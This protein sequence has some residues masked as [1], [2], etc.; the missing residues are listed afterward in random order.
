MKY[1]CV[2]QIDSTDCG[3]ACL[4]TI[5]NHYN[6]FMPIAK[7]RELAGTDK[8]G[9]NVYGMVQAARKLGFDADGV[10]GDEES[11]F[12][13]F[14][15]PAIAHVVIDN[16]LLHYVVIHS[17]SKD[18][19]VVADP[20]KGIVNYTPQDFLK[21]WSGVMILL[22]PDNNFTQSKKK[23][24]L[25]RFF[26]MVISQKK[27]LTPIFISSLII[28]ATGIL[29]SFYYSVIMDSILL[30][31]SY[32][33][34]LTISLCV[35]GLYIVKNIL[36]Y[37]RGRLILNLSKKI[38]LQLIPEFNK[39]LLRLPLSFFQMRKCGEIVSRYSDASKIRDALSDAV[40]TIMIDSLMALGGGI[41]L[42]LQNKLL[43]FIALGM[44]VLYGS[45]VLLY[46]KPI[47]KANRSVME[48]NAQFSAYLYESVEGIETIKAMNNEAISERKSKNLYDKLW[49]SI[50]KNFLLNISQSTI[51]GTIAVIGET[52]ILW[53][54]TINVL[55]G[56]MTIGS[57][58]T[59]HALLA[60]FLSPAKN[61][62]NLQP[63]I[64][65]AVVA[66]ERLNDVLDL[67]TENPDTKNG[68]DFSANLFKN[69][70]IKNIFFRYGT[71]ELVLKDLSLSIKAGEK[72][73]FVGESGSG[74][75]TL[76]KLLLNFYE[77]ESG[78][79]SIG[80]EDVRNIPHLVLRDRISYISQETFLFSG[81]IKENLLL[82]KN[83]ATDDEIKEAC[84]ISQ[85]NTFISKMPL[86]LDSLIEE[87]GANLSGGQRQ[88]LAIA[89][90]LLRKPNILIMDEATSNLDTITEKAIEETLN[91]I[92][93][94][95][96]IIIIAHRLSTIKS[97]DNIYVFEDGEIIEKGSHK[98]LLNKNGAYA[99]FWR[100]QTD[101][102]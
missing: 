83:D 9:T 1:T 5:L 26:S 42:F 29:A 30:S 47:R 11:L 31:Q 101:S 18:K 45:V 92:S 17:I 25:N 68:A 85:A 50:K 40:L 76:A 82:A 77:Q 28:T 58:I 16:S 57:L 41:I 100:Q 4:A 84:R 90:A 59:F 60:Y 38:D 27:L 63:T 88:R 24:T 23:S 53:I 96:T 74:K 61:L 80:G 46:N 98:E 3:A 87:N 65:T 6:S 22:T 91:E 66:A 35:L 93:E 79:I 8:Q 48:D 34:L 37:L 95:T 73:A 13:D 52:I 20:A 86:G 75:T 72:I 71:R 89:R 44:L 36:E 19:I 10:E 97:C 33:F 32:E 51:V 43:F 64:Q 54:G 49:V 21:I 94:D 56:V 55:N 69:I 39:H 81:T 70:D 102:D 15:L 7:I 2:K 62:L 99:H 67:D 12:S 14:P 78:S